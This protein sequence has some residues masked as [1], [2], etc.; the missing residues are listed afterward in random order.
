MQG[1]ETPVHPYHH[2][3]SSGDGTD[4]GDYITVEVLKPLKVIRAGQIDERTQELVSE[5]FVGSTGKRFKIDRD[6]LL[7]Y[8]VLYET[9]NA[10]GT[11]Y[12]VLI[13][14]FE[15]DGVQTLPNAAAVEQFTTEVFLG[16]RALFDSGSALKAQVVAATSVA[17]IEAVVDNR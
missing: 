11:F 17:E 9:R 2:Q 13:N 7:E 12:P 8:L 4:I 3:L 16:Y 5:G 15:M 10:V 14:T 1:A 6:S